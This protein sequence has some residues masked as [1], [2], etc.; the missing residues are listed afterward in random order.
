MGRMAR[1][2]AGSAGG[3][4]LPLFGSVAIGNRRAA[5]VDYCAILD[6]V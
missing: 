2:E 1:A 5:Q 3:L 6:P 4:Q